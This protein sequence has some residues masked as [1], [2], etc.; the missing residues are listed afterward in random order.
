M[1]L[2]SDG[3]LANGAEPWRLP[4]LD[5]FPPI[6][7]GFASEPNHVDDDG[8]PS[9]LALR[10]GPRDAGPALG[11]RRAL[12][13]L[14]HRIGGL[15]KADGTGNVSY[16][17]RQPRAHGP[18]AARQDRPASPPT[19]RRRGQRRDGRRPVAPGQLGLDLCAPSPRASSGSARRGMK[20]AH[21]HLRYL[22]PLPVQPGRRCWPATARCW[23]PRSISASSSRILRA[24]FL[25]DAQTTVQ[26]A[27]RAVP[28]RRDRGGHHRASLGG[29][30]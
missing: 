15:E 12:P 5:T 9:L 8:T 29:K 23:C 6:E 14:E 20:A 19:S 22:N 3:Y 21:V 25:V 28:R 18:P 16:D 27:R 10:P 4:D 13:G 1:I 17:G 30:S 7:P 26:D 11:L 24:E 2:L